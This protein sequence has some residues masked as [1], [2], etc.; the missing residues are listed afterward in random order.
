MNIH[1]TIFKDDLV[2]SIYK[3]KYPYLVTQ[4]YEF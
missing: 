4:K 2:I 3:F 1:S